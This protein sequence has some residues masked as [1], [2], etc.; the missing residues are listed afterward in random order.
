MTY[1][2][3]ILAVTS[4]QLILPA[5]RA[6]RHSS[7]FWTLSV[8]DA[9]TWIECLRLADALLLQVLHDSS[10]I[11]GSNLDC[12][13]SA[14]HRNNFHFYLTSS[15]GN[16][17]QQWSGS[18]GSCGAVGTTRMRPTSPF[19]WLSISWCIRSGTRILRWQR[20]WHHCMITETCCTNFD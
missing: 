20:R 4:D 1:L 5:R 14:R 2:Y 12:E 19:V 10:H 9:A 17:M 11:T 15:F 18:H 13:S 8:R 7:W 6:F 16:I 3:L